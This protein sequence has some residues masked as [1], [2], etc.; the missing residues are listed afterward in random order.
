M[1]KEQQLNEIYEKLESGDISDS[2][3]CPNCGSGLVDPGS[4]RFKE[5]VLVDPEESE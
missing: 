1:E 5:G 3:M 2:I 4:F